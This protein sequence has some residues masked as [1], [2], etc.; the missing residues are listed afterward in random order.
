M[1]MIVA[2]QTAKDTQIHRRTHTMNS[3]KLEEKYSHR[4]YIFRFQQRP[5]QGEFY[6]WSI[7]FYSSESVFR[8]NLPLTR[9]QSLPHLKTKQAKQRPLK[10][11]KQIKT[12]LILFNILQ[13]QMCWIQAIVKH[14]PKI[15]FSLLRQNVARSKMKRLKIHIKQDL[16]TNRN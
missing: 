9:G 12:W 4:I 1:D 11:T 2:G 10:T 7:V 16:W 6:I 13:L 14:A 8:N 5:A 15:F 3:E